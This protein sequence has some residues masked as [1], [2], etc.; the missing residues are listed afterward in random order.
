[1]YLHQ[2]TP[3]LHPE[4]PSNKPYNTSL[5]QLPVMSLFIYNSLSPVSAVHL[6]MDVRPSTEDRGK[7]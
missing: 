1:M 5:A 6:N 4:I 7:P 3:Q 2:Y